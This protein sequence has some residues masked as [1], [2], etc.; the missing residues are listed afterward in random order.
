MATEH[1][2]EPPEGYGPA[3]SVVDP[4]LR[5]HDAENLYIG[6]ASTF[7]TIGA[8]QPTLTTGALAL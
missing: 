7:V 2:R 6:G 3:E 4:N 1:S 5:G 8:S